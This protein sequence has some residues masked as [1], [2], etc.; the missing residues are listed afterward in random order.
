MSMRLFPPCPTDRCAVPARSD[1]PNQAKHAQALLSV[2]L[3]NASTY[4]IRIYIKYWIYL[5]VAY[6]FYKH[7][8]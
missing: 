5:Y 7:R 8:H 2:H 3:C 4:M 1:Q 6:Q